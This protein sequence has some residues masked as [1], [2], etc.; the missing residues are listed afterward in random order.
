MY[1]VNI[2]NT[3]V[4]CMGSALERKNVLSIKN[5]QFPL[6]RQNCEDQYIQKLIY[7]DFN[8]PV[9]QKLFQILLKKNSFALVFCYT[10]QCF[11]SYSGNNS[12]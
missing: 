11:F 6:A 8:K 5:G 7:V 3:T 4:G 10:S 12:R 9:K 1:R 2:L